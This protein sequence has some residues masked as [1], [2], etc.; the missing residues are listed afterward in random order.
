MSQ[1]Q[2]LKIL[3]REGIMPNNQSLMKGVGA[4]ILHT[5]RWAASTAIFA[6]SGIVSTV[7]NNLPSFKTPHKENTSFAEIELTKNY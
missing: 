1:N 2:F 6:I 5:A 4:S 3:E 7:I